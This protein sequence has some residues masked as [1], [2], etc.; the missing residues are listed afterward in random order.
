MTKNHGRT[1]V[2][3]YRPGGSR[4]SARITLGL[5]LGIITWILCGVSIT[6]FKLRGEAAESLD[7]GAVAQEQ[8]YSDNDNSTQALCT[9]GRGCT[10]L[11]RN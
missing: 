9:E 10:S 8:K 7:F 1:P 3:P 5:V 2:S 4:P 6:Q 11:N